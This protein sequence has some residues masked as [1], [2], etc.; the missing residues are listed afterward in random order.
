MADYENLPCHDED[1]NLLVV[2]EAPGGSALKIKYEPKLGAFIFDRALHLGVRYPYDWGF[3]PSTCADDGDPLDA[4]V[5]FD[6]PTASGIVIPSKAV[7]VVRM[8]QKDKGAKWERNDRIIA[9]PRRDP[10]VDDV[11]DL[12]GRVREELEQFFVT[13]IEMTDKK[14]RV[15]GWEGPGKANRLVQKAAERYVRGRG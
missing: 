4:M 5:V 3:V 12:P 14:V 2:V 6:A 9:V 15:Q 1:G 10:R 13:A 8:I 7:G 11:H